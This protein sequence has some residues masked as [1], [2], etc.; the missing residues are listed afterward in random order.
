[1]TYEINNK[2]NSIFSK[3]FIYDRAL[4]L[5]PKRAPKRKNRLSEIS[6]NYLTKVLMDNNKE[7]NSITKSKKRKRKKKKKKE[8]NKNEECI[9]LVKENKEEENQNQNKKKKKKLREMKTTIVINLKNIE[10]NLELQKVN[11]KE[12]KE[13]NKENNKENESAE[14]DEYNEEDNNDHIKNE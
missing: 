9:N 6:S 7:E 10:K 14:C 3:D 13:N 1:M 12:K 4:L 2:I 5:S 11:K 8:K